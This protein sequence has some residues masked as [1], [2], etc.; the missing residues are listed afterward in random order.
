MSS[1]PVRP[2]LEV[3]ADAPAVARQ[4]VD[5]GQLRGYFNANFEHPLFQAGDL[6]EIYPDHRYL[7]TYRLHAANIWQ[8]LAVVVFPYIDPQ[9]REMMTNCFRREAERWL[10]WC[11]D[12]SDSGLRQPGRMPVPPLWSGFERLT[13]TNSDSRSSEYVFGAHALQFG[14]VLV[15]PY[16][17]WPTL[18]ERPMGPSVRDAVRRS[19]PGGARWDAVADGHI[20]SDGTLALPVWWSLGDP[21]TSQPLRNVLTG[22]SMAAEVH[23]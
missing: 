1:Q 11:R 12:L 6:E 5:T 13:R 3:T 14:P 16:F 21:S 22:I 19:L 23:R 17:P 2:R 10:R 20:I 15:R 7:L 18:D 4:N 8:Q 9:W